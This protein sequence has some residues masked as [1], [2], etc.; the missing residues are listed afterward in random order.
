MFIVCVT[1]VVKPGHEADFI[2]ASLDNAR[3]TRKEPNNLRFTTSSRPKTTPHVSCFYE[4]YRTK[5]DFASHQR[6]RTLFLRWL[7][8]ASPTGCGEPRQG[9]KH[10]HDLLRQHRPVNRFPLTKGPLTQLLTTN[11]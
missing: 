6:R 1:I 4:V 10:Q 7:A 9:V 11:H 2:T 5:E 3:N 8:T